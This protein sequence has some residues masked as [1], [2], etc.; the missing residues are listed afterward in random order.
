MFATF[1]GAL[2]GAFIAGRYTMKAVENDLEDRKKTAK[3][4]KEEE[5]LNKIKQLKA[6][7]L[8]EMDNLLMF[9][10]TIAHNL[11]PKKDLQRI[12]FLKSLVLYDVKNDEVN[13][14]LK[15]MERLKKLITYHELN[16]SDSEEK[17]KLKF[18]EAQKE[19]DNIKISKK[20]AKVIKDF[21]ENFKYLDETCLDVNVRYV[22]QLEEFNGK[23]QDVS[24]LLFILNKDEINILYGIKQLIKSI[25]EDVQIS[26]TGNRRVGIYKVDR[27]FFL[28]N[29]LISELNY[30]SQSEIN[31]S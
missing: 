1:G 28:L 19:D 30:M 3:I 20:K 29:I 10:H 13:L 26:E 5:K 9:N 12:S 31:N 15:E 18:N 6:V 7:L 22:K 14:T 17:I 2:L 23:I 21:L 16:E 24:S 27:N 11:L 25:K 8:F 4:E